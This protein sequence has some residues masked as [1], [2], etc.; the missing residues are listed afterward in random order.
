MKINEEKCTGCNLC[1]PYCCGG[2]I[3]EAEGRNKCAIDQDLC[4]ECY[5]CKWSEC[6]PKD[7]FEETELPWPRSVR[8]T[9]SAVKV[10]FSDTRMDG[11]GT[12][13]MKTNDISGRFR[14]G[15]VGFTVDVGRP[16]I[17]A[18]FADVEKI[19]MAVGA[20]GDGECVSFVEDNPTT[21]LMKDGKSGEFRDD[22]RGERILS[23]ILEFKIKEE[24]LMKVI[25]ALRAVAEEVDTVFSVGCISRCREDGSIPVKALLDEAGVFYRPNG[26]VNIGLGRPLSPY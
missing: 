1:I 25:Q 11:R 17:G 6:C 23:C 10:A 4:V 16:G 20:I 21:R 9:F 2:A 24:H 5:V 15:E 3:A 22:V 14:L 18:S 26:K 7:A 13:E 8:H 12:K 19:A